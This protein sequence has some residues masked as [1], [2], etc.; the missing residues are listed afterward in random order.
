VQRSLSWNPYV[1]SNQNITLYKIYSGPN[2]SQ[3]TLLDAVPANIS[4]YLDVSP[5]NG[6]NTVY[7]VYADLSSACES[8]RAIRNSSLSNGTGNIQ[9]PFV[10]SIREF[11]S[12][13]GFDFSIMP[14]PND[15]VF[16]V[17]KNTAANSI[18]G[19][20][21]IYDLMGN[22]VHVVNTQNNKVMQLNLSHLS[23]G[24]Y[25]VRLFNGSETLN[26]RLVISK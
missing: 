21:I 23:S 17:V 14:N 8:T 20:I 11:D 15:G 2:Y 24:V 10:Q 22:E 4:N 19:T 7:R 13:A 6:L 25:L 3:L 12:E 18:D 9:Q 1:G 5:V 16:T 26:K